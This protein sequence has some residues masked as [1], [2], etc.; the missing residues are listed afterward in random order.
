MSHN[1]RLISSHAQFIYLDIY[2]RCNVRGIRGFLYLLTPQLVAPQSPSTRKPRYAGH[3]DS[4]NTDLHDRGTVVVDNSLPDLHLPIRRRVALIDCSI[5]IM[6]PSMGG[7]ALPIE[8]SK[9]GGFD[10]ADV[11]TPMPPPGNNVPTTFFMASES[12]LEK[13]ESSANTLG[14]DSNFGIQSLEE[15]A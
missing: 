1:N 5:S 14:S 3:S 8:S 4:G 7:N 6:R 12:M 13:S 2:S 15:T 9:Q 10:D 11:T